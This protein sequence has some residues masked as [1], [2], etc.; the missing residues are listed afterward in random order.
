[1]NVLNAD[2]QVSFHFMNSVFRK[3]PHVLTKIMKSNEIHE[4]FSIQK[5]HIDR[6]AKQ[7]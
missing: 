2:R 5:I 6:F 1:M 3:L 7:K 4:D